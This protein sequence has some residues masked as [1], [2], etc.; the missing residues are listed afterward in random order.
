MQSMKNKKSNLIESNFKFF[1]E[2]IYFILIIFSIGLIFLDAYE[3]FFIPVP[4]IGSSF[5]FA[6]AILNYKKIKNNITTYLIVIILIPQLYE[7]FFFSQTTSDVFYIFL[8]MF[9]I[10][11]FI[12]TLFF[13]FHYFDQENIDKL[14][15]FINVFIC[16]FI[17]IINF[18]LF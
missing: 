8:R 14:F 9:N 4:W 15:K 6:I 13:A 10:V 11:S 3:I 2:K 16:R 5:L 1:T 17:N 18:K 7:I 12:F